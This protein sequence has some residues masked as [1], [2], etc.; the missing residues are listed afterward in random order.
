MKKLKTKHFPC[1]VKI[2]FK[3][4]KFMS[5]PYLLQKSFFRLNN[6]LLVCLWKDKQ[7]CKSCYG[8]HLKLFYSIPLYKVLAFFLKF[9]STQISETSLLGRQLSLDATRHLNEPYLFLFFSGLYFLL[10]ILLF[11]FL[12]VQFR[13]TLN[14]LNNVFQH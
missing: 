12:H 3:K 2:Q 1:R 14:F 9:S 11:N 7:R 8:S 4:K 13:S 6:H 5:Q 10:V